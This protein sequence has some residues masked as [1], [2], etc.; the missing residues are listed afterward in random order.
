MEK[1]GKT[2]M[3]ERTESRG[4]QRKRKRGERREKDIEE[5][6]RREREQ[7]VGIVRLR[8]TEKGCQ[9]R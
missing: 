3:R 8:G 1:R 7:R 5:A 2:G 9:G 4:D 6:G